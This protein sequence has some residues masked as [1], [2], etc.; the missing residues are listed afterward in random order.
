MKEMYNIL[1][2][3]DEVKIINS[4]KRLLNSKRYRLEYTTI[5]EEAFEIVLSCDFDIILCDQRM[6]G[7]SGV[8]VLQFIK[9][10]SPETVRIL[11]TGYSDIEVIISAINEGNIFKYISKPWS[12]EKLIEIIEEAIEYKKEQIRKLENCINQ[13]RV[14][15]ES[16][17]Q[18]ALPDKSLAISPLLRVVQAKDMELYKHCDKVCKYSL[19]IAEKLNLSEEMKEN[20]KYA[21]LLHDI[22]KIAVRDNVLYKPNSLDKEEFTE[23]TR[24]PLVGAEVVKQIKGMNYIAEI[25]CQHHEKLNGKGYPKGLNENEILLE[26]KVIAVADSYDAIVSDRV[27]RKGLSQR[28]A[29]EILEGEENESYDPD[30]V[31]ALMGGIKDEEINSVC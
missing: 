7:T 3:D 28:N 16:Q 29:F 13:W 26:A 8:E 12:N 19:I 30:I 10:F 18:Q 4:I 27:Y 25:I 31:N 2:I 20:I 15:A 1:I 6:P 17:K 5:P 23:I 11:I 21:A 9:R 22:G 24:H 14:I